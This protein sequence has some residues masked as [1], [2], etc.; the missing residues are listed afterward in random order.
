M[1]Y[2]EHIERAINYIEENLQCDINLADCARVSGY[3]PYHFLRIFRDVV[4]GPACAL[5]L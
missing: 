3:S 5:I 1:D 2:R 4:G